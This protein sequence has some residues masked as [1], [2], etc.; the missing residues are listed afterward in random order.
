MKSNN[1]NQTLIM[2]VYMQIVTGGGFLS[3][4]K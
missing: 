1:Y 4:R 2:F 3:V